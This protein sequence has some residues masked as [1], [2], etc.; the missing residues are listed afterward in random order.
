MGNNV[1]IG[2]DSIIE[3]S[4]PWLVAIGD[5]SRIGMRVTII[6]HFAGMEEASENGSKRTVQIEEDVWIGPS[7]TILPNVTIGCGSVVAAGSTVTMAVPPGVFVQGNPAKPV[8]VC[9]VPM[10]RDVTYDQFIKNLEPIE[11]SR[12]GRDLI[13]GLENIRNE[14]PIK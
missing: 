11:G 6:G 10:T 3:T 8:A 1:G 12:T 4:C 13:I 9:R 7:V 14:K 5:R 2:Y